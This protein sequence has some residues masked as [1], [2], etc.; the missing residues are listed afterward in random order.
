[1]LRR[2]VAKNPV[3]TMM[4]QSKLLSQ[5]ASLSTSHTFDIGGSFEVSS[6]HSFPNFYTKH[7][8]LYYGAVVA[9]LMI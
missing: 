8:I 9:D 1:M 4:K 2:V 6:I 7:T 5:R 3:A